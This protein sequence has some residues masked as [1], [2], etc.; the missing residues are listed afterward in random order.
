M[1]E[2][3]LRILNNAAFFRLGNQFV[4]LS[5]RVWKFYSSNNLN[6]KIFLCARLSPVSQSCT[7]EGNCIERVLQTFKGLCVRI[8]WVAGWLPGSRPAI[9]IHLHFLDALF[10]LLF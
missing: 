1:F 8:Q 5:K 3:F 4:F 9:S 6:V 10:S 7:L 2:R